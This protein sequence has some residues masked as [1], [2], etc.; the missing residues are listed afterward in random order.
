MHIKWSHKFVGRMSKARQVFAVWHRI[1]EENVQNW[2]ASFVPT[3]FGLEI[4]S[5]M[6]S[7]VGK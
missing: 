2:L 6:E 1:G 7:M 3:S 4:L 5:V